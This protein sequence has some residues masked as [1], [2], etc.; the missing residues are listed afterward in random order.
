MERKKERNRKKKEIK[1]RKKTLRKRQKGSDR[2]GEKEIDFWD[3]VC[4]WPCLS[5]LTTKVSNTFLPQSFCLSPPTPLLPFS[6]F[7]FLMFLPSF[8]LPVFIFSTQP[9]ISALILFP[10]TSPSS[11]SP[12]LVSPVPSLLGGRRWMIGSGRGRDLLLR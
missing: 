6:V 2:E 7:H 9:R 8:A 1:K 5:G 3:A 11:S 4:S 10:W 12:S